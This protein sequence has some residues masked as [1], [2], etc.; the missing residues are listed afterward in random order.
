MN[1]LIKYFYLRDL[2]KLRELQSKYVTKLT[3]E[4]VEIYKRYGILDKDV[5]WEEETE[6]TECQEL[7]KLAFENGKDLSDNPFKPNTKNHLEWIKGFN[8]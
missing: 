4:Q 8:S 5:E 7:G 1:K 2:K 3:K 6:E